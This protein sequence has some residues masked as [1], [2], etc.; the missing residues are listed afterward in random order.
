ME[1]VKSNYV[2]IIIIGSFLIFAMLGYLIDMLRNVDTKK[3]APTLPEEVSV[4]DTINT[5]NNIN[6]NSSNEKSNENGN[7][8][9]ELLENYDNNSQ[10]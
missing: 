7:N 8:P 1:F 9:D 3:N 10:A 4:N 5:N 2:L 6:D